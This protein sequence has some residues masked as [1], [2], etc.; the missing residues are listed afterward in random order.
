MRCAGSRGLDYR[1]SGP[2]QRL[3]LFS[4][5][6]EVTA[7]LGKG[8]TQDPK[9]S[10]WLFCQKKSAKG[11]LDRRLLYKSVSRIF[12][13]QAE[14]GHMCRGETGSRVGHETLVWVKLL[15]V[16]RGRQALGR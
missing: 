16:S 1:A 7:G 6:N 12:P 3:R 13:E 14:W 11:T 4:G 2:V 9:G 8:S 10:P 15:Y 5:F